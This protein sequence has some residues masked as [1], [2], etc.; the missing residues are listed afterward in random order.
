MTNFKKYGFSYLGSVNSSSK[1]LK[2]NK[3]LEIDTYVMYLA[4]STLSG[5]NVCAMATK[6]CIAGCLNT[7]GRAKMDASYKMMTNARIN[8][9]KFFYENRDLFNSML[10]KELAMYANRTRNKGKEFAAR[11]NGTSDL[12]PILFKNN[13]QNIL[14]AFPDVIFYDYTKILNRIE[15]AQKYKNYDLTFSFSGYN[16]NDCLVALQNNVR[17]AVVFNVQKGKPLPKTWNGF[18]VIDGDL[19]DYRPKDKKNVIVGLRWKT[20]RNREVNDQIKQSPFVVQ[21]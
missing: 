19:Y 2:T 13:G 7:S 1:I 14:E 5:K 15:L 9:T 12:S 4:P 21:V 3:V 11:L 16:W 8:K 6:E 20:I 18:K 17:V 10:F